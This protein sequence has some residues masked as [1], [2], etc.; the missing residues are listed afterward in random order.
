MHA[1]GLDG[2][3]EGRLVENLDQVEKVEK[4]KKWKK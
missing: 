1:W 2:E 3:G 4:W